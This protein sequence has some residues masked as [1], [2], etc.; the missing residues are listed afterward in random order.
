MSSSRSIA[1]ARARRA[2]DQG[3]PPPPPT[4]QNRPIQSVN[5]HAAFAQQPQGRNV[6]VATA[7][8]GMSSQQV[9]SQS[10]SSQSTHKTPKLSV[11]DAIGLI[12]LRLG[13]VESILIELE[14]TGGVQSDHSTQSSS[15]PENTQ[16]VD[17][18]ILNNIVARLDV[19]EKNMKEVYQ[20]AKEIGDIKITLSSVV[21]KQASFEHNVNN[22]FEDINNSFM[23]IDQ[24]FSSEHEITPVDMTTFE[25]NENVEQSES[26]SS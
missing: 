10:M 26:A 22:R 12:T 21:L 18:S 25:N 5:S 9:S 20:V 13:R 6:R 24:K 3:G 19:L 8:Q 17:K 16:L 7:Q 2:G 15:L 11:S 4:P 14:H 23:D 1:A